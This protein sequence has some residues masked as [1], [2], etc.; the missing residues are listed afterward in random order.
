MTVLS[1]VPALTGIAAK[2]TGPDF[3]TAHTKLAL[4]QEIE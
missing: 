2:A 1:I 3:G 4:G